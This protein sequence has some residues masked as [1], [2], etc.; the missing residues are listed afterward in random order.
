M[1]TLHPT[2]ALPGALPVRRLSAMAWGRRGRIFSPSRAVRP[3]RPPRRRSA[4]IFH[5]RGPG[6]RRPGGRRGLWI[7]LLSLAGAL[8]LA[9]LIP[10]GIFYFR[11]QQLIAGFVQAVEERDGERLAQLVVAPELSLDQES[12]EPL[13]RTAEDGSLEQIA[14]ALR[15]QRHGP[16]PDGL[17][18]FQL[19]GERRYLLFWE[20]E[21]VLSPASARLVRS[22][23]GQPLE[24]QAFTLSVDGRA[25]E[26]WP[27]EGYLLE[28]LMPGSYAVSASRSLYGVREQAECT[29]L[30][31][32]LSAREETLPFS[33]RMLEIDCGG[34]DISA[35]TVNG[36]A[37]GFEKGE[38]TILLGPVLEGMELSVSA[39]VGGE[40]VS[41]T[42]TVGTQDSERLEFP[43]KAPEQ[44]PQQSASSTEPAEQTEQTSFVQLP[45]EQQEIFSSA[46]D[47]YL[48]Y[49]QAI[50]ALDPSQLLFCTDFCRETMAYRIENYNRDYLFRFRQMEVDLDSLEIL[51]DQPVKSASFRAA[52]RYEYTYRDNSGSWTADENVQWCHLEYDE[53]SESW[54]MNYTEQKPES[55]SDSTVIVPGPASGSE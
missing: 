8:L 27:E 15:E 42:L 23:D 40:L 55:L 5:S 1:L 32:S 43:Q 48:S 54:R 10:A 30:A 38:D 45:Q 41:R 12:L 4:P 21:I 18:A 39:R 47:Y 49:L 9:Y 53:A 46:R 17:D 26:N 31:G 36:Q 37:A 3:K 7:A 19:R 50:N 34:A 22:Q 44:P 20:Y 29:L 33:A 11:S 6:S 28:N 25:A 51:A 2:G 52:F 35:V 16:A 14:Q 13:F 24:G